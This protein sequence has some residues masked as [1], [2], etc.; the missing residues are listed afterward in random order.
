MARPVWLLLLAVATLAKTPGQ[1]SDG[2]G[3]VEDGRFR[4]MQDDEEAAA[5]GAAEGEGAEGEGAKGEEGE[6]EEGGEEEEE[7]HHLTQADSEVAYMLLGAVILVVSLFYLVNW[8]DDDIRY[9]A[10]NIISMTMSIFSAVLMYQGINDQIGRFSA[11]LTL[12]HRILI[13]F[14]QCC[15][16]VLVMQVLIGSIS[17][18]FFVELMWGSKEPDFDREDWLIADGL[19]ADYCNALTDEEVKHIRNPAAMK[20]VWI[21]T[22]GV[23]VPVSKT[24]DD[25]QL[26]KRRMRCWAM[27]L[28]HMSGFAAINSGAQLQELEVF[29]TNAF[30]AITPAFVNQALLQLLFLS[31]AKLRTKPM[32]D[33]MTKHKDS[34]GA[35][36]VVLCHETV[37]EAENDVSSLSMSYL[38]VQGLRFAVS[39]VMPN[40]E[41]MEEPPVIHSWSVIGIFFACSIVAAIASI[42]IAL[43]CGGGEEEEDPAEVKEIE[44]IPEVSFGVRMAQVLSNSLAMV[45]AWILFFGSRWISLKLDIFDNE[46]MI[47]QVI[48]AL[49]LSFFC[50]IAVFMLDRVD[51][52]QKENHGSAEEAAK[53]I[54]IIIQAI[55]IL[56]GF[57]WEHSFEEGV[58]AVASTANHKRLCKFFLGCFVCFFLVPA[59]R[60]HILMKVL[61]YEDMKKKRAMATKANVRRSL[62]LRKQLTK[63]TELPTEE[64]Q[65]KT[66]ATVTDDVEMA[67]LMEGHILSVK[68][69]DK[70]TIKPFG[71]TDWVWAEVGGKEGLL[72]S[73][74]LS[75][76]GSGLKQE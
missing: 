2:F 9:Y 56:I 1:A 4:Q 65:E 24:K 32:T 21:D 15:F 76:S 45:F 46:S 37:I 72:P 8:N 3:A 40:A 68:K 73:A 70:V 67:P 31:F 25:L 49:I 43:K 51:D 5:E 41:G 44:Q 30:M 13:Q 23:E 16:Y 36:K 69:G 42:V 34:G 35:R 10:M 22:Y 29:R 74:R 57:S 14:A 6:G 11:N 59:W 53:A 54:R 28:A 75:T 61:A 60:R 66:S 55:A 50:G 63:Y 71:K 20:S 7:E 33:A 19:R 47:G 26:A 64:V 17:G 62:I 18:I 52:Y 58:A 27:L 12:Y 38:L 48:L 39:G